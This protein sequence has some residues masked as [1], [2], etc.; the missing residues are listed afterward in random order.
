MIIYRPWQTLKVLSFDLD[1]TLYDNE[2]VIQAAEEHSAQALATY[3]QGQDTKLLYSQ[4]RASLINLLP[5]L[6][7]DVS[8]LRFFIYQ[9]LLQEYGFEAQR[10]SCIAKELVV[11][12][13]KVRARIN[14]AAST[15][16]MLHQLQQ[17]FTL[18]AVTNGN[19]DLQD[20]PLRTCFYKIYYSDINSYAKPH[21]CLFERIVHDYHIQ[22][23]ELCHIGD[24]FYTDIQGS[25]N[26][27]A[28][29]I[30]QTEYRSDQPL[31]ATNPQVCPHAIITTVQ[32]LA[33]LL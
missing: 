22:V 33:C 9:N 30:M 20:N 32:E 13:I 1:D 15:I 7:N 4:K 2:P 10:S 3:L 23:H 18:V 26:V 12:F 24:N 11:D 5:A 31:L 14:V 19:V 17:K 25:L 8:L 6:E 28:V 29:T 16:A 27:G 21:P